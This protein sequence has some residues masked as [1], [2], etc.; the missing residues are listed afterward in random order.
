MNTPDA[1]ARQFARA[2]SAT[3]GPFRYSAAEKGAFV[4]RVNRKPADRVGRAILADYLEEKHPDSVTPETLDFL[5]THPGRA[6][7]AMHPQTGVV[8]AGRHWTMGEIRAANREAGGHWFDPGNTRYFGTRFH[9]QPISG[10]GGTFFLTS[11][12]NMDASRRFYNIRQ[13]H[14][15][16]NSMISSHRYGHELD[17]AT[18]TTPAIMRAEMQQLANTH[19]PA[20][21]AV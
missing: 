6:W 15:E 16:M 21:E 13:Y 7:V 14:P 5:R 8:T 4:A 3:A 19:P 12:S 10:P 18:Q 9:G 11:E 2:Q 17:D 1:A 20:A